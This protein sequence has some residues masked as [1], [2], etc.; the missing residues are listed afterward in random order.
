MDF[1]VHFF[2]RPFCNFLDVFPNLVPLKLSLTGF[3]NTHCNLPSHV[4]RTTF[5]H[6]YILTVL[7]YYILT[8]LGPVKR[9]VSE[10]EHLKKLN[11]IWELL[12]K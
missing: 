10:L 7:H 12:G 3:I 5:L 6:Y 11:I 1:E 9:Q 4:N 2:Y 8:V